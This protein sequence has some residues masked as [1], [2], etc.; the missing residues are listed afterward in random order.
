MST[1]E[2]PGQT[3]DSTDAV[4]SS[5]VRPGNGFLAGHSRRPDLPAHQQT[6]GAE[7]MGHQHFEPA[8]FGGSVDAFSAMF[9][10]AA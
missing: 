5:E 9:G 2:E 7:P 10:G 8:R 1:H 3:G 6:T 4:T